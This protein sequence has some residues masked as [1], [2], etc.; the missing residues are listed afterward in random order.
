MNLVELFEDDQHPA[1]CVHGNIVKG[2]ACY[3]HSP[4]DD[5]PRKCPIWRAHGENDP[6]KWEVG[7]WS[8]GKC[9]HF[10]PSQ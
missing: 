5:A 8:A 2:H 6:S 1:P 3:C 9:P 7:K 4:A 10:K